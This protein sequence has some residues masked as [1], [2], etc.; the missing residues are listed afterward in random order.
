MKFKKESFKALFVAG[1]LETL[2]MFMSPSSARTQTVS[3]QPSDTPTTPQPSA[4][5]TTPQPSATP[6]TPQ[7]SATPTTPQPSDT[8]TTP[9]PSDTPTTPQPSDTPTTPQPSDTPTTP[10]PSATPTTPQ[11]APKPATQPSENINS[12]EVKILTPTPNTVLDIPA[13]SVIV[14][15]PEGATVEL[16]VNGKTVDSSLIGRTETDSTK[17]IVT[18]TWYG[19]S[20]REGENTL[21]AKATNKGVEGQVTSVKVLVR[22]AADK[23]TIQTVESRIPADGRSTATVKGQLLDPNGNRSNR[24]AVV[25]IESSAGQFAGVDLEPDQPG[26]QVQARQ[27]EFTAN[28]RSSLDAQTVRV[29][30][31]VNKLEAFTQLQFETNLRPSIV[32]GVVDIRFGARG[33][34]YYSSF[35]DFLPT[36]KKNGY[37]LD[38]RAA[39]FASGKVLGDWLFTGAYNS[40]R[41][42]N[43]D[44]NGD[45]RLFRAVQICDQN[46]GVYGDT[47]KVETLTPSK[48]SVYLRLERSARVPGAEPDSV[49]WGDYNTQE[50]ASRSQQF[51]ATTRQ[52]HGF[53]SNY[54][55]G[56]AQITAFYGNNIQGFQRDTIA[57]DGTSGYY[58]LSRRL[59]VEGSE[60]VFIEVEELNRPGT[61]IERRQLNRS[62]YQIDYDRGSLL[63]REPILR[64]DVDNNGQVLVRRIVTTY[65]YESESSNNNIY[66]GRVRYHFSRNLNQESWLGATF[67]RENQGV[68]QFDLYGADTLIA[69]GSK[70]NLVAEYAHSKNNSELMG[71]VDGSAYRLEAQGEIIPGVQG[72]AYYRSA[73][74]GFANNATVS[75]VPGQTRYGA[76]V[77]GKVSSTTN[78]KLQYDRENN[79]GIAPQPLNTFEDLFTPRTDAIPGSKVDNN[80]T[81]ITA[82]VQQRLGSATLDLDYINRKREDRLPTNPQNI[83]SSQLRSRV[84]VPI[85]KKITFRAQNE[86][87]L[88][89]QQDTVYPDRTILGLDWAALPGINV[90]LNQQFFSGG[91]YKD[92]SITSLDIDGNYKLGSDTT[93]IGRYSL[94]NAE[95]MTGSLGIKQ[96]LT[97]ASGLKMDFSYER[98]F[99]NL[100]NRTGAGV[101]FPQP[102][103]PGQSASSIGV[104]GGDSYSVGIAYTDN[105]NFQANAR[106]EH[107]TS[108]AASNTVISGGVTGK[109]SPA[110]TALANY[111]QASSSNQTIIGLGDTANLKLG[112]AYRDPNND[113]FNALLRYEYRKN[114]STIPDTLLLGSGTGSEDNTLA[115]EAIY[116]PNWQWEFYGKYAMRDSVSYLAEDLVG[117]SSV[118]LGQVRTTYRV[119]YSMDLVGEARWINQQTAGFSETG[120]L[121]EAGYYL[122][123]NLRLSAGYAFGKVDD[124]DFSGSRSAGGAYFGLTVKLNELFEGFGLQKVAP[125]QQ[126]ESVVKPVATDS[127]KVGNQES[128]ADAS[129]TPVNPNTST[130]V[131]NPEVTIPTNTNTSP[132]S[133][134]PATGGVTP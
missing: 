118:S 95:S 23:I 60:N 84:T 72:Q 92:N 93:V 108:S 90:R 20:F 21:T 57:P 29:R 18:Q 56:N 69:L 120:F 101:Q 122:T 94:I 43:Q 132:P 129:V 8:P 10:Q 52:L 47:S 66:G 121:I 68:R 73:E 76:Q 11:P 41:A 50:F 54:N 71:M 27:G 16:Q 19:I 89:S 74:Q 13:S 114:P 82:G 133:V 24:D 34:D 104:S 12:T 126:Q 49:M 99:G 110:L 32:T 36:D 83:T 9:Q 1:T 91:Q 127:N 112:L 80:L 45:P 78:V 81:T 105:P 97:I 107:R 64:T 3:P 51:T 124:R 6:T 134:I 79:N 48:D 102:F 53:K 85:T 46:Y 128:N 31:V 117:S 33:T 26:F 88:S 4:T 67:L 55:V 70:A 44:C 38:T 109:I 130:T 77:T 98:I 39:V 100:F 116:S 65:Q 119:G 106:Y 125:P 61:V 22:G 63:F 58:F 30:A 5:P 40:D 14:Q 25:T 62:D 28:L 113:S 96:G 103:A 111:Q 115:L 37:K 15:F 42:L 87:N 75:F 35:R 2:G 86:L 131:T 7:P 17:H 59:L 123:P